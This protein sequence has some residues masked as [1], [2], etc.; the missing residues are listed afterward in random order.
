[1][2]GTNKKTALRLL[3]ILFFIC[4]VFTIYHFDLLRFF[5]FYYIKAN[6]E[7]LK[8]F[9]Q[10]SPFSMVLIFSATYI[11]TVGLSLPGGTI[12]GLLGGSIFGT[13]VGSIIISFSSTIGATFAFLLSRFLFRDFIQKKFGDKLAVINDGITREG[14]FYLFGLRLI[15]IFPFFLINTIMGLTPIKTVTFFWV[16]QLGM[17]LGTIVYVNAGAELGNL[18]SMEG[19]FSPSFFLSFSVLGMMPLIAKLL[20]KLFKSFFYNKVTSKY[21]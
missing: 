3:T 20:L 17:L 19:I 4:L 2:I 9:Y 18:Q 14:A 15:P 12:L 7:L 5:D 6:R 13:V 10:S 8:S 1:M 11:I 21:F 16:S